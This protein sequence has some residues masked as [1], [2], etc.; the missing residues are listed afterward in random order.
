MRI[1][2][3]CRL[4]DE[5]GVGR[6]IRNLIEQLVV[7]DKENIYV[8]FALTKDISAISKVIKDK[9]NFFIV[10]T[11]IH[12]HGMEEQLL[13]PQVIKGGKVDLMHFPYFSVPYLYNDPFVVTIHDLI[14]HHYPTGEAT[15]LPRWL[16]YI[17]VRGYKAVME[18]AVKK[19]NKILTV[20]QATKQE[21]IDHFYINSDKIAVIYEGVDKKLQT[22]S[23]KLQVKKG[24]YF[25]HVGNVYPH[26]NCDRLVEAFKFL[27]ETY[28]DVQ[29][30]FVG[31]K[32]YFMQKLEEKVADMRLE[33]SV[34]FT[35]GV[36]DDLLANYYSHAIATVIPSL[37]E[38]FGLP[39]LEA[40]SQK[41]LIIASDTP[42][43]REIG[44]D[45]V[46]YCQPQSFSDIAKSMEKALQLPINERKKLIDRGEKVTA[47]FSW[48]T[49]AQETIAA[50]ESCIGI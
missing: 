17:K 18:H 21:I 44:K 38:G 3:D 45:A 30:V 8:F 46:L 34:L 50:Y 1:G 47:S 2:I 9:T 16:Y 20:S 28:E 12:W 10:K 22:P 39:V 41:C 27:H 13:F 36:D 19:A 11:D 49:M 4:W 40:M 31:E 35:G 37:M 7:L 33:K 25:L 5:T 42:A 29:L 15:T 24:K 43:M 48:Q 14:L 23:H 32:D 6:Y 26:K